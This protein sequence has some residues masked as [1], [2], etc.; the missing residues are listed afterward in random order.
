MR[1]LKEKMWCSWRG[2]D[3]Q[4]E[5]YLWEGRTVPVEPY[6]GRCLRP[7]ANDEQVER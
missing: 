1:W 4:T 5:A 3:K 7:L 2:H 6:C